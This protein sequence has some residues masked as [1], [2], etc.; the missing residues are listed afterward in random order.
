MFL[1]LPLKL[2]KGNHNGSIMLAET[3]QI[4]EGRNS[5][6]RRSARIEEV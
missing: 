2:F 1:W 5:V 6:K 3:G 4:S